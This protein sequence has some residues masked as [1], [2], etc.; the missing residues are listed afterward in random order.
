LKVKFIIHF[1]IVLYRNFSG[2]FC[3]KKRLKKSLKEFLIKII[4]R[5]KQTNAEA[6][7][8][9][10]KERIAGLRKKEIVVAV[11]WPWL[12]KGH[13]GLNPFSAFF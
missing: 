13:S 12:K 4:L 5:A 10:P 3:K 9:M 8:K 2:K 1:T 6:N 11:G 7:I